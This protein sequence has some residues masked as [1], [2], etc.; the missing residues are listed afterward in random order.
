MNMN[1]LE[2]F[3]LIM[4]LLLTM[5]VIIL[6]VI[7]MITGGV[8]LIEKGMESFHDDKILGIVLIALG[9]LLV[10]MGTVIAV[11]SMIGIASLT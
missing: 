5:I 4:G 8:K 10:V 7:L 9:S 6:V 3:N 2:L 11:S 1:S